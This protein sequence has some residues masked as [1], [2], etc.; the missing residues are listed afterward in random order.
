MSKRWPAAK[1]VL[2]SLHLLTVNYTIAAIAAIVCGGDDYLQA[3]GLGTG[4]Q[5]EQ[6]T[7]TVSELQHVVFPSPY[8]GW[9]HM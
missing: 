2:T 6:G 9:W 3:G 5:P 1:N 7:T 4:S 8:D